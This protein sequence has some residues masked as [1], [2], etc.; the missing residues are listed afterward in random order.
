MQN[1]QQTGLKTGMNVQLLPMKYSW[2]PNLERCWKTLP[3]GSRLPSRQAAS[4]R[5]SRGEYI[6]AC[7]QFARAFLKGAGW[8]QWLAALYHGIR[9]RPQQKHQAPKHFEGT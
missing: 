4:R 6:I 1:A 2:V 5:L 9:D 8:K 3:K 7:K